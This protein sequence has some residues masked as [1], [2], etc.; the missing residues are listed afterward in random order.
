MS[1]DREMTPA[2]PTSPAPLPAS[3]PLPQISDPSLVETQPALSDEAT[4]SSSSSSSRVPAETV[5]SLKMSWSGKVSHRSSVM[6]LAFELTQRRSLSKTFDLEV[7]D[8]D[9]C[10]TA[11]HCRQA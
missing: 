5:I 10:A 9:R 6:H 8:Q 2:P 11:T 7:P 1:E 3:A 4:A